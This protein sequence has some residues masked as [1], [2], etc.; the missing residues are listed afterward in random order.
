M[1][2]LFYS[3][4]FVLMDCPRQWILL[5]TPTQN[6][7]FILFIDFLSFLSFYFSSY[8]GLYIFFLFLMF[9]LFLKNYFGSLHSFLFFF[10][11]SNNLSSIEPAYKHLFTSSAS[12]FKKG[13]KKERIIL[14]YG[15][16]SSSPTHTLSL[17][18]SFLNWEFYYKCP[19]SFSHVHITFVFPLFFF[20]SLWFIL[21]SNVIDTISFRM[22]NIFSLF[23]S[24][25]IYTN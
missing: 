9:S 19:L 1:C 25:S 22:L 8:S 10:V 21:Y 14:K 12:F 16:Y 2:Y 23:S 11:L 4:V 20:L 24:L 3:F 15:G 17:S 18:L 7:F 6:V 13:R 5:S